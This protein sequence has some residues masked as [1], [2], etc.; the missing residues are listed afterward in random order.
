MDENEH[1][2]IPYVLLLLHYLN[3]WKDDHEGKT[4]STF[5]EKVQFKLLIK[6]GMRSPDQENFDEAIANVWRACGKTS[7]PADVL[8]V[9]SD[10][11]CRTLSS[12]SSNFWILARAVADFIASPQGN[13]M[14]PVSGILPDMKS[15]TTRYIALQNTYE[16]LLCL[17]F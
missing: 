9:F 6:S 5:D 12:S 4:P 3:R 2:H 16:S 10:P 1:A 13:G 11:L 17:P 7:I 15:D 8:N 14:L